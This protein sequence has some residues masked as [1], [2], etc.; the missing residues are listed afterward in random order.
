M[1]SQ[2]FLTMITISLN[3]YSG[4]WFFQGIMINQ[5]WLTIWSFWLDYSTVFDQE[6]RANDVNS[7]TCLLIL[8]NDVMYSSIQI[9]IHNEI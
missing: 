4:V 2:S 1:F 3:Q 8:D 7:E 5:S 9:R 6:L